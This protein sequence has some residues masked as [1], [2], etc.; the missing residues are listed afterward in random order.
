MNNYWELRRVLPNTE[1][2]EVINDFLLNLKLANR[3]QGTIENYR[4]FLERFFGNSNES[5]STLTSDEIIQWFKQNQGHLK[6]SSFHTRLSILA[7]FYKF[8]VQEEYLD[9]SPMKSRWFP[10]LPEPIPKYLG[11][12]DIAKT[13]QQ[14][15]NMS[16][17]DQVLVEFM[18]TSG[19][20]VG[21]VHQLNKGDVDLENRT[22]RVKGKGKKIR[23][24]HFSEK[25]AIF[26]ERYL[27]NHHSEAFFITS[28]GERL[29]I[30]GIQEVIRKLGK[31]AQLPSSLHPH[32]FRHTFAT[33]LL[34]KGADLSFI[35]DELGHSN[36]RTTQ[37]YARLP[38]REIIAL[39][40]K[41]MG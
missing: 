27:V 17:R 31:E 13:R 37:I 18:L 32:R 20:R 41:Y 12:T 5:F 10:S 36:I 35:A 25:C 21:E 22:A 29:S 1:N 9:R 14:S 3:S 11:K 26:M 30:R 8:C 33:E 39:Y 4:Q 38:Q 19:C 23:D 28:T 16:L 7:S 2:T 40:R 15:E 34:S 6:E 24:V